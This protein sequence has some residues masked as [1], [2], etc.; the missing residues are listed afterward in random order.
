MTSSGVCALPNAIPKCLDQ[1]ILWGTLILGVLG[2]AFIAL[3]IAR[4]MMANKEQ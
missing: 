4:E 2:L 1:W 3:K